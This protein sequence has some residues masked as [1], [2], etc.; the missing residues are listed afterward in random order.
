MTLFLLGL[1][2]FFGAHFYS[3]LRSRAPE[4]DIKTRLGYGPYM[5]LYSLVSLVGLGLIIYGFDASRGAGLLYSPPTWMAHLNL[6]LMIPAMILLI[7]SQIPTGRLKKMSK[8]PMLLAVKIWAVGHLLAN[9]EL[10]SV[11]LFGSFLAFAVFDRIMVKKR[12]DIGPGPDAVTNSTM[13][14]IAVIGGL[15]IWAILLFWLH[16]ILFGV[17]ALPV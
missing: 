11:I 5:G 2:I 8:H 1:A 16:P 10:N 4:K 17:R 13:D 7:A 15:A 9:G 14:V 6:V 3:A 12:G